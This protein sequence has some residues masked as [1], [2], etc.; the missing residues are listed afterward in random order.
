MHIW[1]LVQ[2]AFSNSLAK[3]GDMDI[4]FVRRE[5]QR[6]PAFEHFLMQ[7]NRIGERVGSP[8]QKMALPGTIAR[9]SM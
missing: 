9:D 6:N 7:S 1:A 5:I 3:A 4:P 8:P 2:P